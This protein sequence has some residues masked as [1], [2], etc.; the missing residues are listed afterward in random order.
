MS[1]DLRPVLVTGANGTTGSAVVRALVAAGIPTRVLVRDRAKAASLPSNIEILVGE[2]SDRAALD[3]ACRGVRS[4]FLASFDHPDQLALQKNL[5]DASRDAGVGMI[6]RL[7]GSS[8]APDAASRAMRIHATGDAQLAN[9]GLGYCILKPS[10]FHQNF[11]T[12]CPGGRLRLP[13]GDGRLP[14]IDVRDIAAVA[15]KALTEPGHDGKSY[16]LLGPELLN[17]REVAAILSAATGRDFVYEDVTPEAWR[18]K[19]LAAG[20]NEDVATQVAEIFANVKAGRSAI[21]GGDLAP[22]LGR[23]GITLAAF[24]RDHVAELAKQL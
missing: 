15:V 14:F 22:L 17:H 19:V 18:Q 9:S 2:L 12:Y 24:A 23:P 3:A 10:W 4:V 6:V 1:N 21:S 5:I 7:S 8:A 11:F 13:A 16:L 20:M